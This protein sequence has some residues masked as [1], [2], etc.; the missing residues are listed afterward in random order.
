MPFLAE[1]LDGLPGVVD[2]SATIHIVLEHGHDI[3]SGDV[4]NHG[5]A[6]VFFSIYRPVMSIRKW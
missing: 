4:P 2:L 3:A 6:P 1:H 5:D